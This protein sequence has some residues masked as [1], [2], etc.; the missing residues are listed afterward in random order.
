MA[1]WRHWFSAARPKTL[2]ASIVPVWVGSALAWK[3]AGVVN[4]WLAFCALASATAIQIAANF[5]NDVLD[6]KKGADTEQRLGPL[7]M[8][9]S[10]LLSPAEVIVLSLVALGVACVFALPLIA[11]RGWPILAIGLPS[12]YFSFGYSGGPWPLAFRGLGELFV[13]FFFGVVAVTGSVFVNT[14]EWH[15]WPSL[16][17][18][19]QV[20]LFSTVLIAINNLRDVVED[21]RSAKRTLAVRFGIRFAR[22][23]IAACIFAPYG[24]G[25]AWW[26]AWLGAFVL[27]LLGL[28]FSC[29]LARRILITAPSRAYNQFLALAAAQLLTFAMLF[30]IAALIC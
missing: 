15:W 23:E 27:P 12:L 18:G 25:L 21:A 29:F 1:A 24:L 16:L 17:C 9:A 10:G 6:F 30:S 4:P 5:F 3:L 2:A 13:F 22:C 26:P 7:R 8:T 28:P 19:A 20:G 14:G 11:A